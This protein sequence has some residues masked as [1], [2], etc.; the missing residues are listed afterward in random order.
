MGRFAY[1]AV[2]VTPDPELGGHVARALDVEA[3]SQ[4]ESRE[5]AIAALGHALELYFEDESFDEIHSVTTADTSIAAIDIRLP[6]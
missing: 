1:L 4:G 2:A 5:E 6:A 3:A